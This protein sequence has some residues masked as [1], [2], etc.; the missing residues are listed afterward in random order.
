MPRFADAAAG[1]VKY[2]T[3]SPPK[4]TKLDLD[5]EALESFE[6]LKQALIDV[7]FLYPFRWT[8]PAVVQVDASGDHAGG[9][10]YQP[11]NALSAEGQ[12]LLKDLV[13]VA[14]MSHPFNN[15]Q[16][17]Y[18]SQEREAL[19][20]TLALNKWRSWIE[21]MPITVI[22]DH[23]SLSSLRSQK[24]P[25]NRMRRFLD[26]IEH[27][28]PVIVWKPGKSNVVADWLSRP[29]N[30]DGEDLYTITVYAAGDSADNP[31]NLDEEPVVIDLSRDEEGADELTGRFTE[32]MNRPFDP[33]LMNP[34]PEP[35]AQVPEE[36]RQGEQPQQ[37]AQAMLQPSMQPPPDPSIVPPPL[38][39]S[40]NANRQGNASY[41]GVL[42]A[43]KQ[44]HLPLPDEMPLVSHE[45]KNLTDSDL[46]V[47]MDIVSGRAQAPEGV[48][49]AVLHRNFSVSKGSLYIH[50]DRSIVPVLNKDKATARLIRY[51][52]DRGHCSAGALERYVAG[53]FWHPEMKLLI[54]TVRQSCK[55][56]QLFKKPPDIAKELAYVPSADPFARWGIDFIGPLHDGTH[57][58]FAIDYCT[59]WAVMGAPSETENASAAAAVMSLIFHTFGRP[60]EIIADSGKAFLSKEFRDLLTAWRTALRPTAPYNPRTNGK[61]ERFNRTIK[62]IGYG[63]LRKNPNATSFL[64]YSHALAIYAQRPLEH[65]YTPFYLAFGTQQAASD[66]R[67]QYVREMSVE[68]ENEAALERVAA[69]EKLNGDRGKLQS[70][71]HA[72][73]MARAATQAKKAFYRTF[74]PG[75]WVLRQRQRK[76]KHE[77]FYDGPFL[78]VKLLKSNLV[79]LRTPAGRKVDNMTHME[80]L[81]PAYTLDGDPV[82]SLWHASNRLL[83][84]ER[85]ALEKNATPFGLPVSD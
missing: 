38:P 26:T 6:K 29:P 47:V 75:D 70:L 45:V 68:E 9:A 21:G 83:Q 42:P 10:L 59:S 64:V 17:R 53:N 22:T 11:K 62:E 31:I 72:K 14:F 69:I 40:G 36:T 15:T 3:G 78:V 8:L 49:P 20:L 18:S 13:P 16:K 77:P 58:C 80:N 44:P 55:H 2:L 76:H 25:T 24:E 7:T 35:M 54:Q 71:Q 57:I 34:P 82:N 51:H 74:K 41:T 65:G 50:T 60:A 32:Q 48:D 28:D 81:F 1:L 63:I 67:V 73:R 61:I 85:E 79:E 37:P 4:G 19:A 46:Q 39:I 27:F 52:E 5:T 30:T 56:C 66:S 33:A 84:K 12:S 43:P 23:Q